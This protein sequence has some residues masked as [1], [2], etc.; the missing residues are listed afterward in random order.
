MAVL[1]VDREKCMVCGVCGDV[2]PSNFIAMGESGPEEAEGGRCIECGHCVAVCPAS[3]LDHALT[4]LS[5][6]LPVEELKWE[7]GEARQFLRSRRSIRTYRRMKASQE[8]LTELLDVARFAPTGSNRQGITFQVISDDERLQ[9][10]WK[11]VITWMEEQVAAT[12]GRK[13]TYLKGHIAAARRGRDT[14][15]RGAPHLILALH[16]DELSQS[17]GRSN[18]EFVLAYAE[19]YAPAIGLGTC[20]AGLLMHCAFNGCEP[21]LKLLDIPEGKQLAGALMAGYPEHRYPRLVNRRPL[22]ITWK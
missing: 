12:G 2:C 9:Q 8:E 5:E 6:Q 21:V 20:W 15:L 13:F 1:Q 18:A 4:P 22:D 19:L 11:A 7:A 3:A 14:I 16:P 17:T 10:I